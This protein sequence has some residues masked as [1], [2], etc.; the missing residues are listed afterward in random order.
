MTTGRARRLSHPDPTGARVSFLLDRGGPTGL[1][2]APPSA[3]EGRAATDAKKGDEM[4]V[5]QRPACSPPSLDEYRA[6]FDIDIYDCP[7]GHMYGDH[8]YQHCN[9]TMVLG[10]CN[11]C[12]RLRAALREER[13]R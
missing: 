5:P 2:Q 6:T 11:E 9:G 12:A 10:K 4:N 13:T 8:D 3:H 1:E 7:C